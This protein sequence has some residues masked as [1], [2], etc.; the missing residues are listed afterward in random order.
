MER[1]RSL[2]KR[3]VGVKYDLGL[4]ESPYIPETTEP[5]SLTESHVPLTLEAAQKSLVL[6]ENKNSTL[7]INPIKQNI[8]KIAL[9][10][11]FADTFNY[12][13]YSGQWGGYPVRNATPM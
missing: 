5:Q 2:V 13:D 9:V 1:L 6:L 10:G 8:T 7:P 12:G 4:F 3:V 11:P